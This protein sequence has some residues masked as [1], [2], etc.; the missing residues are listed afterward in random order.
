MRAATHFLA[1]LLLLFCLSCQI[2]KSSNEERLASVQIID[3]N[4]FKET[5]SAPDRLNLYAE[6]D[7]LTAQPYEKVMR[8]YG[9]D[10]SGKTHSKLTTYHTNGE[11]WQYL[12]VVNGRACGLYKEWHDNGVLR[13]EARVIEGMGDLNEKAQKGWIFDEESRVWD[14]RGQLIAKMRYEKGRLEGEALYYHPN[15][16]VHQIVPYVGGL[17]EGEIIT[18]NLEGKP[19][20]R[21]PYTKDRREGNATFEGDISHPAYC[22]EWSDDHLIEG[23]YYDFKGEV[24]ATIRKGAGKKAFYSGGFLH[25]LNQYRGG[26]EE[27]G[28]EVFDL[29]GRLTNLYHVKEGMRDGEEWIYYP[30]PPGKPLLP[31]LYIEWHEDEM[32][33]TCRSYY[34][35]GLLESER[36]MV[37]NKKHG[38]LSAWYKDGSLMLVEEYEKN[39][40]YRGS[41]MKRG[42]SKPLSTVEAGEGT[43]TLHDGDG[44]FI[45]RI[46]YEKGAPIDDL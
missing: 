34:P 39:K 35:S 24:I 23:T 25:S 42:D 15:G 4:G 5:I 17:I 3:R 26:V 46:I 43:A 33:G 10:L 45:R 40:L 22:E 27:G 20:G 21:D 31:K 19:I 28:V 8:I 32:R 41:Y 9:R 11:V 18:Y 2:R 38:L 29:Q 14:D 37:D 12:E 44:F 36:E 6:A 7:F 13:L 16:Q 1:S 30:T